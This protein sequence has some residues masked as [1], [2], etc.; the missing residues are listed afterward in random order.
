M[1]A[2]RKLYKSLFSYER[3]EKAM[4]NALSASSSE[5]ALSVRGAKGPLAAE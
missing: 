4:N 5:D 3:F 2:S 1:E